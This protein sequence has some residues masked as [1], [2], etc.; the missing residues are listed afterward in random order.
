MAIESP[1]QVNFFD[2]EINECPYPSYEVLRNEAPVWTDPV[3]GMYFV[4]ADSFHSLLTQNFNLFTA[5]I[6]HP[7]AVLFVVTEEN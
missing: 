6:Y 5:M 4:V 3:T 1:D 2:K 7:P